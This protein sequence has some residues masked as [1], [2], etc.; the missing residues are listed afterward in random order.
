MVV[1]GVFVER[2]MTLAAV[3]LTGT[4]LMGLTSNAAT[5]LN[6]VGA[7]LG[8]VAPQTFV[9]ATCTFGAATVLTIYFIITACRDKFSRNACV[10]SWAVASWFVGFSYLILVI[11]PFLR[12][13]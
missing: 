2:R 11:I 5:L 4:I 6:I 13:E 12:S 10:F 9:P 7:G 8:G 1:C 3:A